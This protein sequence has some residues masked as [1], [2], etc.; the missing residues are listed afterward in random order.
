MTEELNVKAIAFTDD[1]RAFT[2]YSFKPELRSVGPK[3]G[4]QLGGIR[5][6]LAGVDG[7][8]AMDELKEK[9]VLSFDVNGVTVEL[10]E[11][12][13][14]IEPQQVEG[15]ISE[16]NGD[17]TVVLDTRLTPELIEEGF[18]RELIS[19]IQT[20]R[21]EA[22]FEVMDRI[23]VYAK[24]SGTICDILTR[25]GGQIRSDVL[26]DEIVLDEISGYEKDWSINGENVTLG[27]VKNA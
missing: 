12:N 10:A 11:E 3:Y 5:K 7:N 18:V 23:T 25:F 19:K 24:G 2:S 15:F 16:T 20:M 27:V 22:G 17:L 6:Y 4:K 14:L 1:V 9:G 26:A 8:A 21:K 13:L